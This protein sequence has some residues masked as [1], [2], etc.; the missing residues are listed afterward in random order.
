MER[1][2]VP[3]FSHREKRRLTYATMAK[4]SLSLLVRSPFRTPSRTRTLPHA[5]PSLA[6]LPSALLVGGVGGLFPIAKARGATTLE[7]IPTMSRRA[8][9]S[10]EEETMAGAR[11]EAMAPPKGLEMAMMEVEVV[12][13]LRPNQVS[14]N[15]GWA[16]FSEDE[17]GREDGEDARV[18]WCNG[19]KEALRDAD[20]G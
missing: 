11:M 4:S 14:L 20:E 17:K 1:A 10:E 8:G 12:R 16:S 2:S 18:G 13:D 9:R 6:A 15:E 5:S 7:T 3:P 19:L